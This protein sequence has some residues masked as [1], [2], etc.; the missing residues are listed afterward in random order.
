MTARQEPVAEDLRIGADDGK[1]PLQ[2]GVPVTRQAERVARSRY[3]RKPGTR[4]ENCLSKPSAPPRS[5]RR[6]KASRRPLPG[7]DD[8]PRLDG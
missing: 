1:A 3:G 8:G 4:Y 5:R 7:A 2:S 6:P